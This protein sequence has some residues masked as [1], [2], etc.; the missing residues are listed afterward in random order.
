[1]FMSNLL[2]IFKIL[3]ALHH[4]LS[5]FVVNLACICLVLWLGFSR[6]TS[7]EVVV[8]S[9]IACTFQLGIRG[10]CFRV[11][12]LP[13]FGLIFDIRA[14]DTPNGLF[15]VLPMKQLLTVPLLFVHCV[16]SLP[17]TLHLHRYSSVQYSEYVWIIRF[18]I[19]APIG[20]F[21]TSTLWRTGLCRRNIPHILLCN[22]GKFA[23]DTGLHRTSWFLANFMYFPML[24]C[25]WAFYEYFRISLRMFYG[26]TIPPHRFHNYS[27]NILLSTS[28]TSSSKGSITTF[29]NRPFS[30]YQEMSSKYVTGPP[31]NHH[32]L[33]RP[34]HFRC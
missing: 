31:R 18:C 25:S 5:I 12:L 15:L 30:S 6:N 4:Y 29:S 3:D 26:L 10:A 20:P 16:W 22:R 14:Y 27:Q 9:Y 13:I 32:E 24:G 11:A 8:F 23:C 34:L 28:P 21:L 33:R 17:V 7:I 1:M 2:E 19:T